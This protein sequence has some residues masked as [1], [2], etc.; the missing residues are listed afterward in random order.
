MDTTHMV[1]FYGFFKP[2]IIETVWLILENVGVETLEKAK[3]IYINTNTYP[4]DKG[5]MCYDSTLDRHKGKTVVYIV[6]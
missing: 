5:T 1:V 6:Y 3:T 2:D 4:C